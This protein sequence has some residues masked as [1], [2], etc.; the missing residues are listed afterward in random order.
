MKKIIILLVAALALLPSC[1][2]KQQENT[3]SIIGKQWLL[4]DSEGNKQIYD[5]STES[6]CY[7]LLGA[8]WKDLP[9]ATYLV[10]EHS[11]YPYAVVPAEDCFRIKVEVVGDGTP[12]SSLYEEYYDVTEKT[13][14]LRSIYH[15]SSRDITENWQGSVLEKPVKVLR[16]P[17][18]YIEF[19]QN[20]YYANLRTTSKGRERFQQMG[21]N[22]ASWAV[23]ILGK[24]GAEGD[25]AD[26]DVSG[27][28]VAVT[29]SFDEP[30]SEPL[31]PTQKL[32]IA[33]GKGASAIVL[34]YKF[35]YQ[36]PMTLE[37][38][39]TLPSDNSSI[40]YAVFGFDLKPG[41]YKITGN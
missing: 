18:K 38:F 12:E 28:I 39:N 19:N 32:E 27:K 36:K 33:A 25:Y 29:H 8:F 13:F 15:D 37:Q 35:D 4:T 6:G 26:V 20:G 5:F 41:N 30:K 1:K 24:E 11:I 31:T 22:K 3:F 10:D 23:V 21:K 9:D 7:F 17:L 40:P 16:T 2:K 34:L 14:S